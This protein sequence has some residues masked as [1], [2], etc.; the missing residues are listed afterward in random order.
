MNTKASKTSFPIV[1]RR[2]ELIWPVRE[3]SLSEGAAVAVRPRYSWARG[4]SF[5]SPSG[6]DS[7]NARGLSELPV[8][9][10]L[11]Y[12]SRHED[13]GPF[14]PLSL[15]SKKASSYF[16]PNCH[17]PS[18][19]A[20]PAHPLDRSP[21]VSV[22]SQYGQLLSSTGWVCERDTNTGLSQV[23][24]LSGIEVYPSQFQFQLQ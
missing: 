5:L 4:F 6:A 14:V 12:S 20:T 3:N 22:P 1:A 15:W 19:I 11:R 21:Q 18:C 13:L 10:S 24:R 9:G 17:L 23:Y 16:P 2:R 7:Q 8:A